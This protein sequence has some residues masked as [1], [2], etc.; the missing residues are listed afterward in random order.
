MPKLAFISALEHHVRYDGS[1][2]P[3]M[4]S[5]WRPN[6]VSQMIAVS[7]M[8]DAMRSR[9]PYQEPKPDGLII[10]I[11]LEESGTSFNPYLVQSFLR[12]VQ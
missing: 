4:Q 2:Y 10:K 11:L 9:R 7:D 1:G 6:I 8:F 3:D 5:G 12:I